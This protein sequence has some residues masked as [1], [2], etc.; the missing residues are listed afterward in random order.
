MLQIYPPGKIF[1]PKLN[2]DYEGGL[3]LIFIA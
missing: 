3:F 2:V 1:S